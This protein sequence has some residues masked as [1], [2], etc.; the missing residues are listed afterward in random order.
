MKNTFLSMLALLVLSTPAFAGEV[1]G[2]DLSTAVNKSLDEASV[3]I[4]VDSITAW[5]SSVEDHEVE[6]K[7]LNEDGVKLTYGC[8]FHGDTM[9]CHE[10]HFDQDHNHKNLEKGLSYIQTAHNA[11]VAK[12]SKTL[13]RKGVDFSV[14]NS[15]KVWLDGGDHDHKVS[16]DHDHGSDV[17]SKFNYTLDGKDATV[18][19]LC[20]THGDESEFS[21]HYS[22]TGEDEP[23]L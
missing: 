14:V 16:D 2:L 17:W 7:F 13:A 12:F 23:N 3:E 1:S 18:F 4:D 19:V 9:A 22:R 11:A 20:H 10:E 6:V 21:C 5:E 15:L 8:H